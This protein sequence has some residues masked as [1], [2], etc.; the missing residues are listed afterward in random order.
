MTL[1][2]SPTGHTMLLNEVGDLG[3]VKVLIHNCQS[4]DHLVVS[5][6]NVTST[7]GLCDIRVLKL[8]S[9][10]IDLGDLKSGCL[11][12]IA[13]QRT[14]NLLRSRTGADGVTSYDVGSDLRMYSVVSRYQN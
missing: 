9:V 4:S 6:R 11:Q 8:R 14:D 2:G 1:G 3:S 5:L 13:N 10:L 12:G 7:C